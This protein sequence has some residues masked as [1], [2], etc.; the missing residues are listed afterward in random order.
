M[1]EVV[2][3]SEFV[4]PSLVIES[5]FHQTRDFDA[6]LFHAP[7]PIIGMK[8][9]HVKILQDLVETCSIEP[10]DESIEK[11][12]EEMKL[13][14][15]DSEPI[16][17][18]ERRAEDYLVLGS[19]NIHL[20]KQISSIVR[21]VFVLP[22]FDRPGGLRVIRRDELL[23]EGEFRPFDG[24]R[25]DRIVGQKRLDL[26]I[27]QMALEVRPRTHA[28]RKAILYAF[29]VVRKQIAAIRLA[30]HP[31]ELSAAVQRPQPFHQITNVGVA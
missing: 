8:M 28:R 4:H 25:I 9:N 23:V 1:R 19:L 30:T 29:K 26:Q 6:I 22:R 11:L 20:K 7:A 12:L 5:E 27:G 13:D 18:V 16:Q 21:Q 10:K 17:H 24:R 14:N 31:Y 3:I 2:S 15:H